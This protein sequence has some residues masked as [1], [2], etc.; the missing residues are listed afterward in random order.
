MDEIEQLANESESIGDDVNIDDVEL[1]DIDTYPET[2]NS[3]DDNLDDVDYEGKQYKLPKELKDALLRQ[4]DYTKK[5][6]E[7]AAQRQAVEA[8]R[9][10]AENAI[11]FVT[12][13][14]KEYAELSTVN[15]QLERLSKLDWNAAINE[16]PVEAMKLQARFNELRMQRDN[17]ANNLNGLQANIE[18][19]R[20][21]EMQRAIYEGEQVLAKEIPN[22]NAETKGAILKT[23]QIFGFDAKELQGITDPRI[24]KVL[25]AAMMHENAKAKL[26]TVKP[27][28]PIKPTVIA[29]SSGKGKSNPRED[30]MSDAEWSK[31]YDS[32]Q[33]SKRN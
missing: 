21:A 11:Q 24:V 19:Q 31:W 7:V 3:I 5:T 14:Q 17:I 33:R 15:N 10:Q 13:F 18:Q 4:S 2:D 32:N 25:H 9:Q 12:Q 6:Q 16:N 22:W 20:Q 27:S 29:K 8:Q 28:E 30:Q 23:A 1:D 26:K